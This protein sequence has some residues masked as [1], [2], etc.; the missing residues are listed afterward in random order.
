MKQKHKKTSHSWSQ[1]DSSLAAG[2]YKA[3]KNGQEARNTN[4]EKDLLR[5]VLEWSV[6]KLLEGL[7]MFEGTNLALNSYV[8]Q[9][10]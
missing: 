5:T 9:E 6:R 3:A 1:E 10:T 2:G 7:N 4:S 8:D